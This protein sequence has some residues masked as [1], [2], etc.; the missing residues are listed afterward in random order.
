MQEIF[1]TEEAI[2]LL[3]TTGYTKPTQ[4]IT[5]ADRV[6]LL[7]VL[8]DFHLMA[9]VKTEMDQFMLGL[10]TFELID[11]MKKNPLLWKPYFVSSS[12]KLSAG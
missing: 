12:K 6:D 4:S 1:G 2:D 11:R 3:Y 10:N 5:L 9:K 7:H 8:L